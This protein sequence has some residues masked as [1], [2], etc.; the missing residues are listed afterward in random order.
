MGSAT[1]RRKVRNIV[2]KVPTFRS[3]SRKNCPPGMIPRK[4]YTRKYSTAVRKYG[5]SVKR[6]GKTY[7]VFPKASNMLVN[8]KCIKN[9]GSTRRSKVARIGPLRKGELS[10]YGYSFRR[11]ES[12][13]KAALKAAINSYGALGVYRKL[14]AVAKLTS[15]TVPKAA[16]AFSADRNWVRS[17]FGPL[18]KD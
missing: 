10:K 13:R 1:A 8:S 3:L 2:E 16:K 9:V 5:F 11:T 6:D 18:K 7:R 15:H 14:N 12:E 4:S 17:H